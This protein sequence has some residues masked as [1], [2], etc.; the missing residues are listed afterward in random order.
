VNDITE[1]FGG[2]VE[3]PVVRPCQKWR[4]CRIF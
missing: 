4:H 2:E 3:E 1:L